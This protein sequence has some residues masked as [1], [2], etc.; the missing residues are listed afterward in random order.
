MPSSQKLSAAALP[1]GLTDDQKQQFVRDGFLLFR[2][3]IPSVAS[4]RL[5]RKFLDL[6]EER[7]G[8]RF[9]TA[10]SEEFAQF[11]LGNRELEE[12]VYRGIREFPWIIEF[13][14]TREIVA[15]VTELIGEPAGL[16]SKIPF[17]IDLPGVTRELAV[18]HQDYLYVKGS[19]ATI[20]AWIPLQDTPYERGCLMIMPGSHHLGILDH[21]MKILGKRHYPSTIFEREVRYVEMKKGDLLL[22]NSLLLHSSGLNLSRTVRLSIQARYSALSASTDPAMGQVIPV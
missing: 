11:L 22:F 20:T 9:E 4:N 19:T 5:E 15:P 14:R 3:V 16:T 1:H 17:R 13:S 12:S 18:W 7:G 21:D 10:Q 2:G 8:R 6:V